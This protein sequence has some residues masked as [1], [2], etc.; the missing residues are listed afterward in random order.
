[1]NGS[2][3]KKRG[4]SHSARARGDVGIVVH[5]TPADYALLKQAAQANGVPLKEF[6]RRAA[7]AAC[8]RP[9]RALD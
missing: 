1:M 2:P 7:L 9:A 5:V 6:C 3:P 4:G 8:T